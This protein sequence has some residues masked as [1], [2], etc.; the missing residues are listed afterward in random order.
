MFPFPSLCPTPA[1][2]LFERLARDTWWKI[3]LGHQFKCRHLE[4]TFNDDHV[5]EMKIARVPGLAVAKAQGSDEAESGF[6]WEWWIGWPGKFWRYSVQAKLHAY[7]PDRYLHLR[8]WV[9]SYN[10]GRGGFQIDILESFSTTQR[11]IPLYCF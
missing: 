2:L 11:S 9:N 6:D 3:P 10:K 5:F 1:R 4:T 8:H 7:T